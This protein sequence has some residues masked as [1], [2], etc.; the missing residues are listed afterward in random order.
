MKKTFLIL[1]LIY[2]SQLS[3]QTVSEI[4]KNLNI[5]DSLTNLQELRIYK[6]HSTTNGSEVFR[7]YLDEDKKWNAALYK[8]YN[9]VGN[10]KLKIEKIN[11]DSNDKL[12]LV[13]LKI[14][15]CNVEFLP[16]LE[17]IKY[18]LKKS[19][20]TRFE[21]GEYGISSTVSLP[22]DGIGYM[23]SVRNKEKTN[24]IYFGNFD[25]YLKN[26]PEI[27]ELNSYSKLISVIS[28]EFNIWK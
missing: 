21:D 20:I 8:H 13:W 25:S 5:P 17:D 10:V 16:N 7:M 23:A 24:T 2:F 4:N 27:D 22:L 12:D 19:E 26:Y 14:I 6:W 1:L 15:L 11:L 3:G 9:A 28:D 18:K